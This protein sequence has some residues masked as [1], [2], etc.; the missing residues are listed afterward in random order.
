MSPTSPRES[1]PNRPDCVEALHAIHLLLAQAIDERDC[2]RIEELVNDRGALIAAVLA[3]NRT[4]SIAPAERERLMAA[5]ATLRTRVAL[6]HDEI[7]GE[8]RKV[9][10]KL[11]GLKKYADFQS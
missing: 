9:M 2:E 3:W 8:L 6:L 1:P 10:N 11:Q 5:D 4:H 7:G